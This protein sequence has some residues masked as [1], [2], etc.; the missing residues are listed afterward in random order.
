MRIGTLAHTLGIEVDTIRYYEKIGLLPLPAR[1]DNGY[2]RYS[3]T[4]QERLTFIR[5]CRA[6]DMPLEAIQRLLDFTD[7]PERDCGDINQ[8]I[9]DQLGQVQQR[10]QGMQALEQRLLALRTHCGEHHAAADCGILR[11]L[12]SAAH[13]APCAC[14]PASGIRS[15]NG[16]PSQSGTGQGLTG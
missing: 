7:H 10:L 3:E 6:L 4:H 2:R 16:G 1:E 14:H 12:V 9:D 11:E 15:D 13:G 5:H 8:L